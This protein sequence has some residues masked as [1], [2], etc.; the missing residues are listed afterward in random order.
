MGMQV[1]RNSVPPT[2][3]LMLVVSCRA[4]SE[5]YWDFDAEWHVLCGV[6]QAPVVFPQAA[7]IHEHRHRMMRETKNSKKTSRHARARTE[8]HAQNN[9]NKL[10]QTQKPLSLLLVT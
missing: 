2:A 6:W 9:N 3:A 4:V 8:V 10:T 1:G 7:A 5:H